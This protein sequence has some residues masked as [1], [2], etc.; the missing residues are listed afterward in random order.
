VA[1]KSARRAG[2]LLRAGDAEGRGSCSTGKYPLESVFGGYFMSRPGQI[3]QPSYPGES[4]RATRA[5]Q[6][7][8]TWPLEKATVMLYPPV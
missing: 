1:R 6:A 4:W 7:P 8:A 3:M 2:T 5:A